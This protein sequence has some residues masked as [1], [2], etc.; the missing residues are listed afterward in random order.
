M[1][2]L[3]LLENKFILQNNLLILSFFGEQLA[4][5]TLAARDMAVI[6]L[7]KTV[8]NV[9]RINCSR[10]ILVSD[11]LFYSNGELFRLPIVQRIHL[12][13]SNLNIYFQR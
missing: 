3:K 2:I 13:N 1:H 10:Q 6:F 9:T 12:T 5:N 7:H 4:T 8:S 11:E